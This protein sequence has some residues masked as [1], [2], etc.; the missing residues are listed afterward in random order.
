MREGSSPSGLRPFSLSLFTGV[1]GRVIAEVL[2][3]KGSRF[4]LYGGYG[5]CWTPLQY[6]HTLHTVQGDTD[7]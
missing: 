4:S 5:R 1:R 3:K 2:Q 7:V 6:P